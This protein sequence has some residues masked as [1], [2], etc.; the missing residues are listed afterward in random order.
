MTNDPQ[1]PIYIVSKG[2]AESRFTVKT[3]QEMGVSFKVIIENQEYL[4]YSRYIDRDKLLVLDPWFQENYDTL[5]DLG[6]AKSRGPGP[7]RNFAWS[8]SNDQGHSWHWVMDDNIRG[9]YRFNNN[10]IIPVTTGAIFKAMEDFCGRYEN[11]AMAGPQYEMFLLRRRKSPPFVCNT[12]IYSCNLIR[13]DA[14]FKWRGR[15]N[16]DTILSLDMM[17]DGWCTIQF[18][19]FLQ[20]KI[21]TQRVPGG[22]SKEFYDNEGTFYKSEMLAREYPE[23]AK[24]VHKFGR[25]HHQVDYS[26][27]KNLKLKKKKGLKIESGVNNYGMTIQDRRRHGQESQ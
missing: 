18:N 23:I 15:Y 16:E 3:L 14:P 11:V 7:A 2:R 21:A 6:S 1:Y 25:C 20:K 27:F 19:A 8:H 22:N 5:D 17:S 4:T 10:T 26:C 24:V 9:F 13:N 12:R